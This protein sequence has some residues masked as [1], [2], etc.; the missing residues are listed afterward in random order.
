MVVFF[1]LN[2]NVVRIRGRFVSLALPRSLI[3][4]TIRSRVRGFSCR[5]SFFGV[6]R[7]APGFLAREKVCVGDR[8]CGRVVSLSRV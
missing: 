5:F 2:P 4:T 7:F 6:L 8:V 1:G 3:F